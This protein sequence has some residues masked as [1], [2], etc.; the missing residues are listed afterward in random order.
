[1]KGSITRPSLAATLLLLLAWM[2]LPTAPARGASSVFYVDGK[3]GS[4]SNSGADLANAYKTIAAAASNLPSKGAAAGWKIRVVGYGDYVYRERPIPPG[5]DRSGSASAPIVFEAVGYNGTSSGYTMPIVSG[6]DKAPASG[7]SW[8]A[9]STGV[10]KTPWQT[11]PFDFGKLG[12]SLKTAVFEDVTDW[13]WEQ[14][15]LTA[16][17]ATA[18]KGSGGYWWSGGWLY[19]AP[20]DHGTPSGHTFDVVM[21]NSFFFYSST[22]AVDYVTVRGFEVRHSANGIA[23]VKGVDGGT[24]SDDRVIGNLLMGVAVSGGMYGSTADPAK[25]AVIERVEGAYN[26]LQAVKL[27]EGTV[28]AT[29]CDGNFHDN[30]LQGIKVQG[31]PGST[32]YTGTTSGNVICRNSLHHQDFN[33]TGTVYNNASGITIANGA[34]S[35]KVSENRIW[36]ND[37]GIHVV[38]EK[39]GMPA[40]A[41][42]VLDHNQVWSNRRF[43]LN[44]FDGYNGSG[45]GDLSSSYDLYWGNGIGVMADRGTTNKTLDHVTI[46]DSATEGVKVGGTSNPASL[47]VTSSLVTGNGEWGI[48]VVT[49]NTTILDHVGV[50]GNAGGNIKGSPTQIGVNTK[51]AGYLSTDSTVPGFLTITP[52]SYQFAAGPGASPIGGRWWSSGFI[53]V[54]GSTYEA[55]I[56][57]LADQGITTGCSTYLFCPDAPVTRGQLAAFLNRALGLPSTSTDYFTDDN[58]TTFEADINRLAAAGIARGCSDAKFCPGADVTRGQ[59]AAFLVRALDLIPASADYFTDDNGTTFEADINALAEAGIAKGCSATTFCPSS[60]VTRAQ[61]AAFLHRALG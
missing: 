24:A 59:M 36:A 31:P 12:G 53:D 43:G 18:S 35:T 44:L 41:G 14:T 16:L 17:Q 61:M 9:V 23:F 46:W 34:R 52:D 50:S 51:A 56:T 21:R 48:W 26:T 49:G 10:W 2:A 40:L 42:T 5:W 54:V 58:G 8:S 27:D 15:G 11:A 47:T 45:A 22:G 7:K 39:A 19:V 60:S 30:G 38:Q 37:V 6:A 13:L 3:N 28:N 20:R 1:M 29:V 33:P 32:G 57:W 25:D 55:D 4:D